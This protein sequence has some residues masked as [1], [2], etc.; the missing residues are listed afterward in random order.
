MQTLKEVQNYL[1]SIDC[2]NCGG[3]GIS[4]YSMYLWLKNNS[5]MDNSFKFVF[6]YKNFYEEDYYINNSDVLKTHS[7]NA[8]APYHIAIYYNGEYLDSEGTVEISNF[9]WIQHIEEE[10]FIINCLNNVS[11][12]NS[13]FNRNVIGNIEKKL[14]I[15]LNHIEK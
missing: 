6:C 8:I 4:A 11:T 5:L 7:G 15:S 1:N 9:K 10:W 13:M 2:I 3:C 12:W 14:N